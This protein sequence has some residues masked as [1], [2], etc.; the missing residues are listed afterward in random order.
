MRFSIFGR[1]LKRILLS[2]IVRRDSC[3]RRYFKL[4]FFKELFWLRFQPCTWTI[5]G[6]I[7]TTH[8]AACAEGFSVEDNA[9][10]QRDNWN[11]VRGWECGE[12]APIL[13]HGEATTQSQFHVERSAK[14]L[15]PGD[16]IDHSI[17]QY[18]TIS[19]SCLLWRHPGGEWSFYI[20]FVPQYISILNKR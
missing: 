20:V 10:G 2:N 16:S 8:W 4:R 12:A 13:N 3:D 1:C 15:F 5:S 9:L 7:E 6:K 11:A 19:C 17:E 14:K 18:V